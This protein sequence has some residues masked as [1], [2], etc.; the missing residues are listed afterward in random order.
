[1]LC[2]FQASE[3][4]ATI[5]DTFSIYL[6]TY[7]YYSSLVIKKKMVFE[8]LNTNEDDLSLNPEFS[9]WRQVNMAGQ[10][11]DSKQNTTLLL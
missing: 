8:T 10:T 9:S 7:F 3:R 4:N 2:F 5:S 6:F 1:M 11:V